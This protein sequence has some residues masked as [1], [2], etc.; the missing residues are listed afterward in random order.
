MKK[1]KII[2]ILTLIIMLLFIPFIQIS[3]YSGLEMEIKN[4]SVVSIVIQD[5]Q[6]GTL[7]TGF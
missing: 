4:Q 3:Y 6:D 7:G 1:S 5:I 2:I